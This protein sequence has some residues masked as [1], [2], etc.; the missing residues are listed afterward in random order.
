MQLLPKS[1]V[2]DIDLNKI[3]EVAAVLSL[4]VLKINS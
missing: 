4:K 2:F 1:R 3:E